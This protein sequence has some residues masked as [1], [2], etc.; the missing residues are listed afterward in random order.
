[1]RLPHVRFTVWRMMVAVVIL[2][3]YLA[4]IRWAFDCARFAG[5]AKINWCLSSR[6][7]GGPESLETANLEE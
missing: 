3:V 7:R 4:I 1:M 6:P 2:A 5:Q